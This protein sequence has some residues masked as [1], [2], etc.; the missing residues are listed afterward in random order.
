MNH[1]MLTPAQLRQQLGELLGKMMALA[2]RAKLPPSAWVRAFLDEPLTLP[3]A[4]AALPD[5]KALQTRFTELKQRGLPPG[6]MDQARDIARELIGSS[7]LG[8]RSLSAKK[9]AKPPS[10]TLGEDLSGGASDS[11][12]ELG[13]DSGHEP[14]G[15]GPDDDDMAM[16][17]PDEMPP[18]PPPPP[19]APMAA[20]PPPTA[21][22]PPPSAPAPAPPAAPAPQRPERRWFTAG[23]QGQAITEPLVAQQPYVLECA[24]EIEKRPGVATAAAP[25]ASL[26][27]G[28]EEQIVDLTVELESQ[29]FDIDQPKQT[30]RVPRSGAS[31]GKAR[32]DITPRR[33]GPAVL[34]VT[35]HKEGNLLQQMEITLAVGAPDDAAGTKSF[36]RVLDGATGLKPRDVGLNIAPAAGGGYDLSVWGGASAAVKLPIEQAQLNQAIVN[37]R[38]ELMKVVEMRDANGEY[39]F[40]VA[41]RVT[42]DQGAKALE[43]LRDAGARLFQ[44]LFFH[45]AAGADV[46]RVGNF[47]KEQATDR[48]TRL[49]LQILATGVPVPWPLLYVGPTTGPVDWECFLGMRH[50]I[51]QIPRQPNLSIPDAVIVSNAPVLSVSVNVNAG[52]DAQMESDF[53]SRQVAFWNTTAQTTGTRIAARERGSDLIAAL[54]GGADDQ[55]MYFYCHAVTTG[56]G[57][58]NGID[59]SCIVLGEEAGDK[60]TLADLNLKALDG[61]LPGHPL[62]FLNACESAELSAMFYDGFVPYFMAKGARGVIGTECKTPAVFAMDWALQFF[63]MFLGGKPL[64]ETMLEL[65]RSF[66]TK[67]NNPLGLLYTVHC[68]ADTQIDPAVA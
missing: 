33:D 54:A 68:D 12:F 56:I 67:D 49:K 29:D 43:I 13:I 19:P 36:G 62:I 11:D 55:L 63:P 51:E 24:V 60:V 18:P 20:A 10:R 9:S 39:A 27:F 32:F 25:D 14:A 40:Q 2:E 53:V 57:D 35:F 58:R 4:L 52:I 31:R 28:S 61:E 37:L 3:P 22:A 7:P 26:W 41:S 23:I 38:T 46:K 66:W 59:S 15:A 8:A 48:N 5:S 50:I 64:G 47:L 1:V 21:A 6:G 30:L 16:A 42:P 45:P 65:R 34:T 17:E 44:Q